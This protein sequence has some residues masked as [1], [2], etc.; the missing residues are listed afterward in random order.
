MV[1]GVPTVCVTDPQTNTCVK[2]YHDPKDINA[3]GPHAAASASADINGGKMDGFI[4]SFL[5][6]QKAC[7]SPDT[8]GCD[9]D[10]PS[11]LDV[12]KNDY[13]WTGLTYLLYKDNITWA[14][15]LSEGDQSDCADDAML[16][17]PVKQNRNVPGI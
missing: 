12:S 15:Y 2:P 6:A 5:N 4:A 8:L 9:L 7:K 16:C 13:A 11:G 10:E 1:N 14:Y 17:T 3:G